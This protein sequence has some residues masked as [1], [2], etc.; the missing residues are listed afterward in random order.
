MG[1]V[2]FAFNRKGTRFS[3]RLFPIGGACIFEGETGNIGEAK[4][5]E[6]PSEPGEGSFL[7]ASPWARFSTLL[8][9]SVFNFFLAYLM[10]LIIVANTGI[11]LPV[12]ATVS[13]QAELAGL[14]SGDVITRINGERINIY[15]QIVFISYTSQGET[16][17]VTYKRDGASNTVV[18]TPA[19]SDEYGRYLIGITSSGVFEKSGALAIF[20]DA[21]YEVS[22]GM[23]ATLKSLRMLIQ[24][25]LSRND[26]AGPVGMA[27]IVGDTLEVAQPYGLVVVILSMLNIVMILSVNL[28]I[29]NL[30]PLPALD[31]GRLIFVIIEIVR[32]KPVPPEKEG[33]VHLAGMIALMFLMVLVLFND[34]SRLIS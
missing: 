24:G 23:T 3:L 4:E 26:I 33:M 31:G 8:A 14:Q 6:E 34:I 25:R 13:G 32:G 10:G 30:L 21:Y 20:R 1:P 2:L 9:G 18:I 27:T 28:G 22:Y 7:K 19:Y 17:K 12:I 15:R 16:L 5:G 29:I 11:D